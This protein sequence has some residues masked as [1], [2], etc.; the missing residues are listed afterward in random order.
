MIVWEEWCDEKNWDNEKC[1]KLKYNEDDK[2]ITVLV[3]LIFGSL[4]T[5]FILLYLIKILRKNFK[6][7]DD[8]A[9]EASKSA[10]NY[11][12]ELKKEYEKFK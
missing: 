6:E 1:Q 3:M 2:N 12:E 8:K 4:F 11:D 9:E 7:I 5:I 10:V